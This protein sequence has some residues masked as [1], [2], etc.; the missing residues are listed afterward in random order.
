MVAAK[1]KMYEKLL[2]T[3]N[4]YKYDE[5]TSL[6][7]T[8]LRR[9][10][11]EF[12]L[13]ATKELT[14]MSDKL[15][16]VT[17]ITALFEDHCLLDENAMKT[18][19]ECHERR[20]KRDFVSFL[21][22]H[23]K[24]CRTAE[25]LSVVSLAGEYARFRFDTSKTTDLAD[26]QFVGL[27]EEKE[28]CVNF[29]VLLRNLRV[30]W[31]ANDIKKVTILMKL[32]TA[33]HE[34]E[35]RTLTIKGYEFLGGDQNI[36]EPIGQIVMMALY[37]ITE[38]K[39][40]ESYLQNCYAFTRT[41]G[42]PVRL[43]LFSVVARIINPVFPTS[44]KKGEEIH[45]VDWSSVGKLESMP[46][47]AVDMNTRRGMTGLS[48]IHCVESI[49]VDMTN[50]DLVEFHGARAKQDLEDFF[51]EGSKLTDAALTENIH[52]DK[53]EQIYR[54]YP[55]KRRNLRHMT[56][57]YMKTIS[58]TNAELFHGPATE[59]TNMK[60]AIVHNDEVDDGAAVT[61][62]PK[63]D[64]TDAESVPPSSCILLQA[65]R[66]SYKAFTAADLDGGWV[67]KG[68]LKKK[69]I[70]R[71][72]LVHSFMTSVFG[73]IH[74]L[75]V[76]EKYPYTVSPLFKGRNASLKKE[77]ISFVNQRKNKR[78]STGI[79]ITRSNMG[80]RQLHELSS[81]QICSLPQSVWAHFIFRFALNV[82][83]S[84]LYNALVD[85]SFTYGPDAAVFG[86]DMDEIRGKKSC[87][88]ENLIDLMFV[89]KPAGKICQA[90][91]RSIK[92]N[93]ALLKSILDSVNFDVCSDYHRS[94]LSI[95][96]VKKK[97]DIAKMSIACL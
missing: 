54:S 59:T 69:T 8:S 33:S 16:W 19:L 72:L 37:R 18:L 85:S 4:G 39:T 92:N 93:K 9:K 87:C 40:M 29:D 46:T 20:C 31:K 96:D 91:V 66:A 36:G 15:P 77:T 80:L 2:L 55:K 11:G 44:W 47:W 63:H 32:I 61:K 30:S 71:I 50:D 12:V 78:V 34:L 75:P 24:T 48:N 25:C 83:D 22:Y 43:I 38:N 76:S 95:S 14:E 7:R 42:S 51:R 17:L 1:T 86:I 89:K 52:W 65:P 21:L 90:I 13:Q 58:R 56:S 3:P 74:T 67:W 62:H 68:P 45:Q 97:M 6:L 88:P 84:G 64:A 82:G 94:S 79:F 57:V 27:I 10:E 73:D 41:R 35:E 70:E 23:C 28:G 53:S 60:R 81:T 26:K 5:V 49:L